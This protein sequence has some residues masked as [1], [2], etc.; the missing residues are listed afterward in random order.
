MFG[1][2]PATREASVET[3]TNR[4]F[5]SDL[6]HDVS[7]N[8]SIRLFENS[9]GKPGDGSQTSFENIMSPDTTCSRQEETLMATGGVGGAI[10]TNGEAVCS[11]AARARKARAKVRTADTKIV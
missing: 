2:L 5:G 6:V 8:A 11:A 1:L 4:L 7:S 3:P 9:E 10:S